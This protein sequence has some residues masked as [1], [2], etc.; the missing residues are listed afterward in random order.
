MKTEA[1][2]ARLLFWLPLSA[3]PLNAA[4]LVYL[5]VQFVGLNVIT[6]SGTRKETGAEGEVFRE[7]VEV[8][9]EVEVEGGRAPS[10]P[11]QPSSSLFFPLS[12]S[13]SFSSS[14]PSNVERVPKVARH[15]HPAGKQRHGAEEALLL[16]MLELRRRK[17]R[18]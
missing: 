14:C 1:K 17:E 7:E 12:F 6:K 9:V 13:L 8:E 15:D 3:D 2:G 11:F 4:Y 5:C 18:R 10:R 16:M